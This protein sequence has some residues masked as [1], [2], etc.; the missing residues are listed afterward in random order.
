[1]KIGISG[2]S[3][4]LGKAVLAELIARGKDHDIV[5]ISRSD[6]FVIRFIRKTCHV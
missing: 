5:G 1:M 4:Q 2:V 6:D 3:G